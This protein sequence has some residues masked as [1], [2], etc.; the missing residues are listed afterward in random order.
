MRQLKKSGKGIKEHLLPFAKHADLPSHTYFQG[1]GLLT[2]AQ[3]KSLEDYAADWVPSEEQPSPLKAWLSKQ[4]VR[5]NTRGKP[6]LDFGS[7]EEV[8]LDLE[9][10]KEQEAEAAAQDDDEFERLRGDSIT[11]DDTWTGSGGHSLR[12]VGS[13][14]ATTNLWKIPPAHRG[15]VYRYVVDKAKEKIA[16][17][18][19]VLARQYT[20]VVQECK[21]AG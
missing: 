1:L 2:N 15:A 16:T 6:T 9:D 17:E 10:L 5:T 12:N 13:L 11:L 8:E 7:F 4:L 21:I 20:V 14:L 19:R 18:V 3:C